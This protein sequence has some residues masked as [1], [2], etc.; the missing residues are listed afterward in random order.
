MREWSAA[1][2]IAL[3]S[4]RDC[5]WIAI[6]EA[7]HSAIRSLSHSSMKAENWFQFRIVGVT[8]KSRDCV[9]GRGPSS[10]LW[11]PRVSGLHWDLPH[12]NGCE[13]VDR[14]AQA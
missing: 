13:A 8:R 3:R 6:V 7:R 1:T 4:T 9:V 12:L 14:D 11:H 2:V 5:A 10:G